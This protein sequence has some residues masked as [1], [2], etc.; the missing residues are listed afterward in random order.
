MNLS[1]HRLSNQKAC[2][3]SNTSDMPKPADLKK[4]LD[5]ERSQE[6]SETVTTKENYMI[7]DSVNDRSFLSDEM[8]ALCAK[9]PIYRVK[10]ITIGKEASVT[11]VKRDRI[12]VSSERCYKSCF[13]FFCSRR[14]YY[15]KICVES[16]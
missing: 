8:A 14:C 7:G 6:T 12:C 11:R 2:F 9:L 13:L 16:R 10:A 1:L 4:L 5:L 3:L 15:K